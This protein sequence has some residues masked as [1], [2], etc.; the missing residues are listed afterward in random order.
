MERGYDVGEVDAFLDRAEA[1]LR[2]EDTLTA[3]DV[4]E[5]R[6]GEAADDAAGYDMDDVDDFLDLVERRLAGG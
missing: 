4:A 3:A 6:F 5:V 1:T 2:G